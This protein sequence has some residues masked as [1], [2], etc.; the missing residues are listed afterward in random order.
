MEKRVDEIKEFVRKRID[1]KRFIHSVNTANEAVSLAQ[2]YG[3]DMEKAY[4]AGLLHDVAKGFSAEAIRGIADDIGVEVDEY[5]KLNPE[6]MHGK[7]G[8]AIAKKELGIIDEDILSAI[9]WHTTGHKNMSLLE[10][11]IYIADIIEPGRNFQETELLRCLAYKSIDLAMLTG[12]EHV[13][14]FVQDRG[15]SLHPNSIEAYESLKKRR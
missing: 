15:F 4:I 11:I 5:E 13:M 14:R 7:V 10:K 2:A 12:L 9:K 8:A 1:E 6:L 3:A